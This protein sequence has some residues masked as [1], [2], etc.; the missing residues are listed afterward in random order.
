MKVLIAEDDEHIRRGLRE[1]CEAQ[2][3]DV[4]AVPD[5]RMALDRF[6]LERPDLVL[7]DIMMPGVD[8]YDVCREIR[9]REPQGE[10]WL[11]GS[12]PDQI[13]PVVQALVAPL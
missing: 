9:R 13:R 7:L 10:K 2:G 4:F 12:H 6:D 5:G 8:S 3:Y 11:T 1:V